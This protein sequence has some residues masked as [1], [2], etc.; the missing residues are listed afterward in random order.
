[1]A[2]ALFEEGL[3]ESGLF[4]GDANRHA[5]YNAIPGPFRL[6]WSNLV[7]ESATLLTPSSAAINIEN[8]RTLH[9]KRV[10][11]TNARINETLTLDLQSTTKNIRCCALTGYNLT[12]TATVQLAYSDNG[13]TWT[14]LV[15]STVGNYTTLFFFFSL[16]NNRYWRLTFNDAANANPYIEVGRIFLGDYWEPAATVLRGWSIKV[17]DRSEVQR[18]VGQQK[19]TNQ[20]EAITQ[21]A[22]QLP[23][24]NETDAIKNFLN[25]VRRIGLSQ[26][27]FLSLMPDASATYREVTGLYGRFVTIAGVGSVSSFV[28][29]AGTVVFEESF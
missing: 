25:I 21:I 18:S 6:I 1:M 23:P 9:R 26:D 11:R 22:F 17:I 24:L 20:K 8:I 15:Q 14:Q 29:D 4:E 2:E 5:T 3:F 16:L 7:D 27:I 28:Y 19:W 13:S 10:W 12:S